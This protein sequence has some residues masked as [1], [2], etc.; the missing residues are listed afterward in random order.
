MPAPSKKTLIAVCV[1][2]AGLAAIAVTSAARADIPPVQAADARLAAVQANAAPSD[3]E[4]RARSDA[5]PAMVRPVN[6]DHG[7]LVHAVTAGADKPRRR[8]RRH[9]RRR[10]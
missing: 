7:K 3:R 1:A 6:A 9:A 10:R 8:G 5:D 2:A 4:T